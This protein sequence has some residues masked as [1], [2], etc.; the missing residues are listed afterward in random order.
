MGDKVRE[1]GRVTA[2]LREGGDA[3]LCV[4][5]DFTTWVTRDR[6]GAGIEMARD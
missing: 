3:V 6:A 4:V 1:S 5:P 2:D